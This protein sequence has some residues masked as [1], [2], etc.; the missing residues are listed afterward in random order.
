MTTWP[1][2]ALNISYGSHH[3]ENRD[4]R[5]IPLSNNK[6]TLP[7]YRRLSIS[8]GAYDA[9]EQRSFYGGRVFEKNDK[10]YN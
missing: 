7:P 8:R 3:G 4:V 9:K 2:G 6:R 1:V 10:I 5:P